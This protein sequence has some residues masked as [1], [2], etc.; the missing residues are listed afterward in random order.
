MIEELYKTHIKQYPQLKPYLQSIIKSEIAKAS[1]KGS[2]FE[3]VWLIFFSRYIGLGIE[4]AE[5]KSLVE[6]HGVK[7]NPFYQ[8]IL[9]SSQKIFKDTKIDLFKTPKKCTEK[10]LAQYLDIFNTETT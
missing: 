8:S 6:N 5:F 9:N 10:T 2:I 3:I 4:K 1:E 7:N